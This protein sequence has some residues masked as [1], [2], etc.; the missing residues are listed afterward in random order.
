VAES[1]AAFVKT[2]TAFGGGAATVADVHRMA[3]AAEGVGPASPVA[4]KASGGV[5]S[6]ADVRAMLAAGASRVGA[7]ASVAIVEG[8]AEPPNSEAGKFLPGSPWVTGDWV[9]K[10]WP[11]RARARTSINV[12]EAERTRVYNIIWI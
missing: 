9:V 2:C 7:S 12:Q 6:A 3:Q 1:G 11:A 8:T 4:V 10:S 5:R